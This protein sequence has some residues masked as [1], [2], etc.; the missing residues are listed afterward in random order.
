MMQ[1]T[2]E[3]RMLWLFSGTMAMLLMLML[4]TV[5]SVMAEGSAGQKSFASP[6]QAVD[7]LV[8]AVADNNDTELLSIL[9]PGSEDLISS[10]DSVADRNS[11]GR[12]LK[13]YEEKHSFQPEADERVVLFVGGKDYPFPI[14][15]IHKAAAWSF[16][17]L[18]GKEEI[19]NRRIGRNELHTIKVMQ[20]YTDAQREYAS[21]QHNG[22]NREFA[23][24]ITSSE[25][26]KDGLYWVAEEGEMA[27]PFG[28]LIA[29]LRSASIP[30]SM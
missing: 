4:L 22:D 18:A 13:A 12:F 20:A 11:R 3:N 7:A 26:M 17:T 5:S 16:D 28:P 10:G 8:A 23:Q 30:I 25:G 14:P 15:I 1:K 2:Y 21:Q 19:L 29:P 27:S 9:G 24:K 6:Q